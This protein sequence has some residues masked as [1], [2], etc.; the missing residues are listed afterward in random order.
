M[1]TRGWLA[2]LYLLRALLELL[3]SRGV[4]VRLA[5]V[6]ELKA[7]ELHEQREHLRAPCVEVL[8]NHNVRTCVQVNGTM[9]VV[10]LPLPVP[11]G[12]NCWFSSCGMTKSISEFDKETKARTVDAV[13]L[14]LTS[15]CISTTFCSDWS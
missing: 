4:L 5:R 10:D 15:S 11:S 8:Y 2:S 1:S 3:H 7:F 9:F 14:L 13:L 12:L 6:V